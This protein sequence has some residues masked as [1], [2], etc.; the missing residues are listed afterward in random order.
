MKLC[1]T[2]TSPGQ[3][4]GTQLIN[5]WYNPDA[6]A[7]QW[8][9]VV[10]PFPYEPPNNSEFLKQISILVF[11]LLRSF[12]FTSHWPLDIH[13]QDQGNYHTGESPKKHS[14]MEEEQ[15]HFK[16]KMP[17]VGWIIHSW[18]GPQVA[19]RIQLATTCKP[20]LQYSSTISHY[21]INIKSCGPLS[22]GWWS[23]FLC[24]Y[25]D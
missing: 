18:L 12:Y 10:N 17:H 25:K 14:R 1:S 15:L 4:K 2:A 23:P 8:Q 13:G 7:F 11:D 16:E 20:R 19:H 3:H 24:I 21:I 22:I 6:P 9:Q 5:A